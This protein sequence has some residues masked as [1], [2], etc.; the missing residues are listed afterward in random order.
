MDQ[1]THALR[2]VQV[3]PCFVV[4]DHHYSTQLL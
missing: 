1:S 2:Q 4:I 3:L